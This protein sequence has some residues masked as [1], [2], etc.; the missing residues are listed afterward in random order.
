MVA[1]VMLLAPAA[2]AQVPPLPL[3]PPKTSAA[4]RLVGDLAQRLLENAGTMGAGG[5]FTIEVSSAAGRTPGGFGPFF[6]DALAAALRQ[7]GWLADRVVP[8]KGA[9]LAN[10][11]FDVELQVQAPR[12]VGAVRLRQRPLSVWEEMRA[13]EGTVLSVASAETPLD[14]ELRSLL[15]L[16]LKAAGIRRARLRGV[17]LT[18][19]VVG[20][21]P[22]PALDLLVADLDGDRQQDLVA[23]FAD[24]VVVI[25][26]SPRRAGVVRRFFLLTSALPPNPKRVRQPLGRLL[27]VVNRDGSR[28][29][30]AAVSDYAH[31]IALKLGTE[32]FEVEPRVRADRLGWPL[33]QVYAEQI[34][35]SG[36]PESRDVIAGVARHMRLD[37]TEKRQAGPLIPVHEVRGFSHRSIAEPHHQP[38]VV[39]SVA[40]GGVG[41]RDPAG[42]AAV[43]RHGVGS[44]VGDLDLDGVAELLVTSA[45]IRPQRDVITAYRL[46]PGQNRKVLRRIRVRGAVTALAVGDVDGDAR[47]EY[48]VAAWNGRRPRLY[49]L[50]LTKP[51]AP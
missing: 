3:P 41:L 40:G 19:A 43:G 1:L 29:L 33:Y 39:A 35:A 27:A 23:L 37:G 31:P 15:G 49:A 8:K 42:A 12:L 50:G 45:T 22:S 20:P 28:T 26:L 18:G 46:V 38:F 32:A 6:S 36:W 48:W 30:L 21:T 17:A 7:R 5:S 10:Y 11:L 16:P 4:Q 47:P 51:S 44:V 34:V 24:R 9:P 25:G 2:A 14:A 13:P